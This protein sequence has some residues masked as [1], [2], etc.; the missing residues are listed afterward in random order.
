MATLPQATKMNSLAASVP[1]RQMQDLLGTPIL[2]RVFEAAKQGTIKSVDMNDLDRVLGLLPIAHRTVVTVDNEPVQYSEG[3]WFGPG[4]KPHSYRAEIGLLVL[5][6]PNMTT[7]EVGDFVA[8]YLPGWY[9]SLPQEAR[10]FASSSFNAQHWIL[11]LSGAED[12]QE[13]NYVIGFTAQ[14]MRIFPEHSAWGW[15]CSIAVSREIGPAR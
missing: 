3:M 8:K 5:P 1:D 6:R 2:S 15:D 12:G 11:A 7:K 10:T 13:C 9:P 14:S 4:G